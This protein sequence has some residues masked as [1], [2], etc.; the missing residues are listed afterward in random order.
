MRIERLG[1]TSPAAYFEQMAFI[2][3]AE[4]SV[5]F[6]TTLGPSFLKMFYRF[7][8][9]DKRGVVLVAT[10]TGAVVGF[11]AGTTNTAAIRT[12]FSWKCGWRAI[13]L[14]TPHI[15]SAKGLRHL[16]SLWEYLG[17]PT[18]PSIDVRAEL[19]SIAT[20]RTRHR[21]GIGRTLFTA[22]QRELQ[23]CGV[24]QFRVTAAETQKAALRFYSAVGGKIAAEVW[25]GPLKSLVFV[26]S[27]D[28]LV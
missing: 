28:S 5:G 13:L 20:H 21:Q 4:L 3:A 17:Q 2:H 16:I 23:D 14:L 11:V 10:E 18:N 7:L 9:D 22:F 25:L 12:S 24:L 15:F 27:T 1:P 26:Y 6:I 8:A 19:L